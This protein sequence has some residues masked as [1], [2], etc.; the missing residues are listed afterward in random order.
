MIV[1]ASWSK[2]GGQRPWEWCVCMSEVKLVLQIPDS[3]VLGSKKVS[4]LQDSCH[5]QK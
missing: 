2:Q 3:E 1:Q 4:V 5:N